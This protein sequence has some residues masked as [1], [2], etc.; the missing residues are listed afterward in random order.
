MY[1]FFINE[2][3]F[4]GQGETPDEVNQLMETFLKVL[5]NYRQLID[6]FR[7]SHV[8]LNPE[9]Q[10]IEVELTDTDVFNE[11]FRLFYHSSLKDKL[12]ASKSQ[13]TV[14]SWIK[15]NQKHP[16]YQVVI[17]TLLKLFTN[18]P[19][20]HR[21]DAQPFIQ[22]YEGYVNGVDVSNTSIIGA[23]HC[24]GILVSLQNAGNWSLNPLT[25]SYT[26]NGYDYQEKEIINISNIWRIYE[27]NKKHEILNSFIDE[28]GNQVSRMDLD[29][30]E[31][32]E[33]LNRGMMYGFQVYSYEFTRKQFYVFK[34]HRQTTNQWFFH[35][36]PE[37]EKELIN[38]HKLPKE[39]LDKLRQS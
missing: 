20:D 3:S 2:W 23:I 34:Y 28:K 36:Y 33:V 7:H 25:S 24:K 32:Q 9:N 1:Y 31:A 27:A 38:T 17:S 19:D 6:F 21:I 26:L 16:Q 4:V 35:G 5:K 11:S 13:E 10:L 12:L 39:I 29:Y 15:K 22:N 14:I 8:L 18:K 37:N 30:E